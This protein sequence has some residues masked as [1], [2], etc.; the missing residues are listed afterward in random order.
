MFLFEGE[1]EPW[2]PALLA[3]LDGRGRE[4]IAVP[5]ADAAAVDAA[6]GRLAGA[7][8]LDDAPRPRRGSVALVGESPL[9]PRL[10]DVLAAEV[11][12]DGE[13]AVVHEEAL[14]PS[15]LAAF[16]R[17]RL[18]EGRPWLLL[19]LQ[20][21]WARVGPL[22]VPGETACAECY[23]ARLAA[24]RAEPGAWRSWEA[25]DLPAGSVPVPAHESAVA[26]LAA[27]ELERYLGRAGPPLLAGRVLVLDLATLESSLEAVL[28][29]PYCP[30]C[31]A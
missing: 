24:N 1:V 13:V 12:D 10:R 28:A 19:S 29:N 8:L 23:R 31:G 6:L 18:A 16:N 27:A 2:L 20:T 11:R 5:G 3:Q 15:E 30:D 9:W 17:R 21:A 25:L 7:G 26:A 14:A 22:F 4:A